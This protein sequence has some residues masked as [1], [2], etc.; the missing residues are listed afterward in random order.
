VFSPFSALTL[1]GIETRISISIAKLK[2]S[3]K[4]AFFTS[5][6]PWFSEILA[7]YLLINALIYFYD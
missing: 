3:V 6:P 4:V 1:D 5:F 7:F 2:Q